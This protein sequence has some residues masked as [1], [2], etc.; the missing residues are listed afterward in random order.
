MRNA[1]RASEALYKY[2]FADGRDSICQ[3]KHSAIHERK[4]KV[5]F[6]CDMARRSSITAAHRRRLSSVPW[7]V[8]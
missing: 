2:T 7:G 4:E 3:K 5:T 8:V 6:M 1:K